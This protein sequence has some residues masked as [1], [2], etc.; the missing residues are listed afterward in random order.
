SRNGSLVPVVVF[1]IVFHVIVL[2]IVPLTVHMFWKPKEYSRPKTFQLVR[3]A[4][5]QSAPKP[6]APEVKKQVE[7]APQPKA[8]PKPQPK[9]KPSPTPKPADKPKPVDKPA[10]EPKPQ[11]PQ[12]DLGELSELLGGMPVPA[13][14]LSMGEEFKYGWYIN[15]MRNK[16]ERNWQPSV[17][18]PD[19]SVVVQFVVMINGTIGDVSVKRSSGSAS[20]DNMALR[21]VKMAAPFGKLPPGFSENQLQVECTLRPTRR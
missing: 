19:L 2:L 15:A 13:A 10:P 21:A 8:E 16:I 4:I 1:S 14:E 3:P 5:P 17:Q 11:P 7:P 9:P 6:P 12:E 20:L 18:N